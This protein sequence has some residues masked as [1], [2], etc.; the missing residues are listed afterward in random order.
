[1]RL[2]SFKVF[3]HLLHFILGLRTQPDNS[4]YDDKKNKHHDA[5]ARSVSRLV[6]IAVGFAECNGDVVNYEFHLRV[7]ALRIR[8]QD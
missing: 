8:L 3:P 6:F 2:V 7:L 5:S 1:M 4:A